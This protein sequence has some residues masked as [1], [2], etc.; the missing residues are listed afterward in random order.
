MERRTEWR[1]MFASDMTD[2]RHMSTI[3]EQLT[4]LNTKKHQKT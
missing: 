3:R 4:Q 2:K 1:K